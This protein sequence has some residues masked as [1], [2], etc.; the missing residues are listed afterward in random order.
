MRSENHLARAIRAGF[1][2]LRHRMNRHAYFLHDKLL[3]MAEA[4]K[5]TKETDNIFDLFNNVAFSFNLFIRD[6]YL[7]QTRSEHNTKVLMDNIRE[8]IDGMIQYIPEKMKQM[9]PD[10]R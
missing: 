7:T 8:S 4:I 1:P 10:D 6:C 3:S 9:P 2:K 5:K